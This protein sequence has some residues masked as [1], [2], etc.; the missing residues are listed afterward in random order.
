M[1]TLDANAEGFVH[2]KQLVA[3]LTAWPC[4]DL[5]PEG[6]GQFDFYLPE[7]VARAAG[8]AAVAAAKADT[9]TAANERLKLTRGFQG[10]NGTKYKSDTTDNPFATFEHFHQT[11][12]IVL[13]TLPCLDA[14]AEGVVV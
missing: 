13:Q 4:D 2:D 6:G 14:S 8:E 1:I 9:G 12:N 11:G 7:E 10:P 3:K 5:K